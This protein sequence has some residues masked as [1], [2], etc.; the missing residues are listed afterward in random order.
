VSILKDKVCAI[1][2]AGGGIGR[3]LALGFA[4]KGARLILSSR[5]AMALESTCAAVRES[6]HADV[7][8]IV[9]DLSRDADALSLAGH[10]GR[11]SVD[12]LVNNA[13][14]FP[15][16]PF[17]ETGLADLDAC[18][19]VNL[20]APFALSRAAAPHMVAQ[21]WGRIVNI[22]SSSA[23]MGVARSSLYCA[24]KHALLGLSRALHAELR[25]QGVRVFCI[26][27]GSV[28][29]RMGKDVQGQ[30]F[31]TFIEPEEVA[32]AVLFAVEEHGNLVCD[33]IRLNRMS[34]Q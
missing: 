2:G 21:K 22:G 28:K 24:S 29:T 1:T 25:D 8:A 27:P 30:D 7:R 26:S 13:G 10:V 9:S 23:Y 5:D 19:T 12:I 31:E 4:A 3:A 14:V 16:G 17:L 20:R 32:R 15:T 18:L 33:E 11:S 6:G 34:Y